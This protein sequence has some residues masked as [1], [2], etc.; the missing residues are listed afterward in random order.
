MSREFSSNAPKPG[1]P[2]LE[3]LFVQRRPSGAQ[4][5]IER[6]FDQVRAALGDGLSWQIHVSP[7]AS[8]GL[9]P[10]L[11]NLWAAWW[12]GRGRI[13]HITGDVYYL[14]LAL[15]G[16]QLVLTIHDC[17]VL[18]R[19]RGWRRALVRLLW[20]EWPVRRAAVVTTIS[21]ATRN[22]LRRWLTPGQSDKVRV[23]PNCVRDEYVPTP[24]VWDRESPVVLQVGTGWNKNLERVAEALRGLSCR[25]WI[26]GPVDDRQRSILKAC[27]LDFECLG[28]LS[29]DE[30]VEAY[31]RCDVVVF[32]SLFEGFGLPI[33]EAQATGRPLITSNRDPMAGVAGGG[34]LLVDPEDVNSIREAVQKLLADGELRR[35]LVERG[36]ENM[37]SYQS[38]AVAASYASVYR[39]LAGMNPASEPS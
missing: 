30:M 32:A 5:S 7:F 18:H 35:A 26:V 31:R 15:P 2:G 24:K 20:F 37:Q 6:L 8:R 25:L 17:A 16:K 14:A 19:L 21:V 33:V 34:A 12:A 9:L 36:F 29:D 1:D 39:E 10:R 28:R 38:A 23:I 3:V 22:D 11:R 27:D 13:C 4:V